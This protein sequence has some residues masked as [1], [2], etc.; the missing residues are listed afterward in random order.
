[1]IERERLIC[2]LI[3]Y[4]IGENKN[5]VSG[6]ELRIAVDQHLVNCNQTPMTVEENGLM[7]DLLDEIQISVLS[8]GINRKTRRLVK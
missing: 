6:K 8:K 5:L 3:G 1:M 2:T 7:Q 4:Y